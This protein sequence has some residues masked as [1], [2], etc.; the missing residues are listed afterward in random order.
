[1]H[2]DIYA[3]KDLIEAWSRESEATSQCS[4]QVQVLLEHEFTF[5]TILVILFHPQLQEIKEEYKALGYGGWPL[6]FG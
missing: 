4:D 6:G 2:E 3:D 1:M 5:S